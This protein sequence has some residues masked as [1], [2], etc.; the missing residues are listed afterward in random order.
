M[1]SAGRQLPGDLPHFSIVAKF[2]RTRHV[3][4]CSL[5]NKGTLTLQYSLSRYKSVLAAVALLASVAALLFWWNQALDSS[6]TATIEPVVNPSDQPDQPLVEVLEITEEPLV[7]GDVV[8]ISA[9]GPT[10]GF[11]K[12]G[13]LLPTD[14]QEIN[15]IDGQPDLANRYDELAQAAR[16]GDLEAAWRLGAG[17]SVCGTHFWQLAKLE[18]RTHPHRR[19]ADERSR[20]QEFEEVAAAMEHPSFKTRDANCQGVTK[21]QVAEAGDW[22]LLAANQGDQMAANYYV[23]QMVGQLAQLAT[24]PPALMR[25][26]ANA[27][28]LMHRDAAQCVGIAFDNLRNAYRYGSFETRDPVRAVA[29][30]AVFAWAAGELQPQISTLNYGQPPLT[31]L[32]ARQAQDL[33]HRLYQA[34]CR[35]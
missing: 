34:Y 29:Y 7:I 20:D 3:L 35:I 17:L 2:S 19:F 23:N 13:S 14:K 9:P 1:R 4:T 15:N 16:A 28:R 10:D 12:V 27:S 30:G 18:G 33:A 8:T 5:L 32:Q 24:D 21:E 26:R 6:S 25:F 31:P 22:L 11:R